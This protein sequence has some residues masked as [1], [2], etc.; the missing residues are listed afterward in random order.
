MTP[1]NAG[2]LRRLVAAPLF[3]SCPLASNSHG[4][5]ALCGRQHLPRKAA[6]QTWAGGRCGA[7]CWLTCGRL[8]VGAQNSVLTASEAQ[9]S[10]RP[11]SAVTVD[12]STK[13]S[14][15]APASDM[16]ALTTQMTQVE[17]SESAKDKAKTAAALTQDN[18][19][20]TSLTTSLNSSMAPGTPHKVEVVDHGRSQLASQQQSNLKTFVLNQQTAQQTVTQARAPWRASCTARLCSRPARTV[21]CSLPSIRSLSFALCLLPL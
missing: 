15:L 6:W 9:W 3:R 11:T 1:D 21:L 19:Y 17:S 20:M 2:H 13:L 18:K 5:T 12:T 10:G 14:H 8:A 16:A 7:G 4:R